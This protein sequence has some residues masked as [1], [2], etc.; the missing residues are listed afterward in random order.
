MMNHITIPMLAAVLLFGGLLITP[1]A[2]ATLAFLT[3]GDVSVAAI[4]SLTP[5]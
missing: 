4:P 3:T 2:A 1:L 5:L